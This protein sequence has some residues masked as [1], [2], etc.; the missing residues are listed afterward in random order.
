MHLAKKYLLSF[1]F[2][3]SLGILQFNMLPII[4]PVAADS[5][6]FNSQTLL[7]ESTATNYGNNPKDVKVIVLRILKTLLTFVAILMVALLILAG[8]KYMTSGGNEAA[9]KEAMGQIKA[10]VIGLI[11]ILASWGITSYI[12]KWL[13]CSTTY[14]SSGSSCTSIF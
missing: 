4:K 11:I 7:Q 6:L 14:N 5:S 13:V 8:F 12:L 2:V 10:L 3:F 1:L 9:M